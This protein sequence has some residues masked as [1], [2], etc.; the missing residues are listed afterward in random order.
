MRPRALAL[1]LATTAGDYVLWHW[2]VAHSH[3]VLSLASG[4]TLPPLLALSLG[5]V[6]AAVLRLAS[7]FLRERNVEGRHRVSGPGGRA[8]LERRRALAETPEPEPHAPPHKL[9]A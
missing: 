9:A 4:L 7:A 3:D 2:S 1:L 8:V 6:G 5:A